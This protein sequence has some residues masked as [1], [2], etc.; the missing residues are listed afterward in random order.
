M[1]SD[2]FQLFVDAL[3]NFEKF[4]PLSR[5]FPFFI[6]VIDEIILIELLIINQKLLSQ[7]QNKTKQ[8]QKPKFNGVFIH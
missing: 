5:K 4:H 8:D 2:Q 1:T 7:K 3:C 6:Y